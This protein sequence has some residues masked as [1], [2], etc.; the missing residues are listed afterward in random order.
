MLARGQPRA[1]GSP[2]ALLMFPISV[3]VSCWGWV[4]RH[5][6]LKEAGQRRCRIQRVIRLLVTPRSLR[7]RFLPTLRLTCEKTLSTESLAPANAFTSDRRRDNAV[8][9]SD[10][11]LRAE[12]KSVT[13][14]FDAANSHNSSLVTGNLW[15]AAK[16]EVGSKRLSEESVDAGIAIAKWLGSLPAAAAIFR[17]VE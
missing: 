3:L 15:S 17:S 5:S 2:T 13:A 12:R 8:T 10:F 6:D 9:R 11:T 4:R 16:R 1:R 14:A 7:A